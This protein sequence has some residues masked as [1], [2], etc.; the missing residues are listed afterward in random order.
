GNKLITSLTL[1]QEWVSLRNTQE[2]PAVSLQS[3]QKL[4]ILPFIPSIG[5]EWNVFGPWHWQAKA[6]RL[7]RYPNFND[8]Y[9][10]PGGNP[11]LNP[12]NGYSIESR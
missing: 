11:N 1:R 4:K 5:A 8:L 12:E 2:L 10:N 9:W 6:S 3:A 7:Y